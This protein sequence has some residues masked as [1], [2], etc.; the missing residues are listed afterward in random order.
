MSS[1]LVSTNP[2]SDF[3][4][5]AVSLGCACHLV[6]RTKA[7]LR[8]PT[9]VFPIWIE[10]AI[11]LG[12]IEFLFDRRG[13]V[14]S[15]FTYAFLTQSVEHRLVNDLN[16]ILH[17]SEWKEGNRLWVLDLVAAPG[18][19]LPTMRYARDVIFKDYKQLSYLRRNTDGVVRKTVT[20]RRAKFGVGADVN[21]L[22]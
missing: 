22:F 11:A 3:T 6:S 21:R 19:L 15:Y 7:Y 4:A 18:Y 2:S 8:A 12:Q 9:A 16:V 10:P 20:L 5:Q 14:V 13:N 17:I 1:Y